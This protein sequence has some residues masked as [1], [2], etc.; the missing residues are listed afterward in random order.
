MSP[1]ILSHRA[2]VYD[3]ITWG[4]AALVLAAILQL[5]LLGALLAGLTVYSLVTLLVPRLKIAS[6]NHERR[7]LLAVILVATLVV[8][9]LTAIGLG[10]ASFFKASDESV[11]ALFARMAEIIEQSKGKL[12]EWLLASLPDNAEDLRLAMVEW[13]RTH[14]RTVQTASTEAARGFAHVLI[15]MV[16]GAML[17]LKGSRVAPG[18]PPL[19]AGI[20][21][22]AL[23]MAEV[24]RRVVFAQA[25]I[26][27]INTALTAIYLTLVLPL[28]GI[29][30]PLTKTLLAFTFVMGLMP[31]VGN[32]VSNSAIFVVSLSQS[33]AL[34]LIS[35]VFLI[36]VHK[37]EY[38]L[39]A[40]IIGGHIR[41]RAWELL[42][43]MLL[44][45]AAFGVAGLIVAP[46][47]YAFIK[48]E[49]REKGLI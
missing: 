7:Q 8:A 39:N 45:E 19:T 42:L 38:F 49:F 18:Q 20:T 1:A 26:S 10:A 34:A 23:R 22:R 4:L 44:M 43:A 48:D 13:L 40:R 32:L 36:M 24:F 17:S 14:A 33:L 31:I 30:L 46:M 16:I 5:H 29:H 11:P 3:W 25:Y 35:L 9:A 6:F 41:A 12:P 37:L 47:A 2:T 21:S 27:G 28:F 15:G